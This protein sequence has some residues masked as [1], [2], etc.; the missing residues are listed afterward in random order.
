MSHM[1]HAVL[2][3]LPLVVF[4]SP[5]PHIVFL[6]TDDLGYNAPGYRNSDLHTPALD[7]LASEGLRIEEYYTYQFCSPTRGAFHTG[8]MPFRHL[9]VE[10]N[11]IP[12]SLPAG[13]DLRYDFLPLVLRRA[14]YSTHHVGKWHQGFVSPDFTPLGRGYDTT[15]G[16]LVGGE[17]HFTQDA[18]RG[19]PACNF[20]GI[21]DLSRGNNDTGLVPCIGQN[22]TGNPTNKSG[23]DAYYNGYTFA[24]EAVHVIEQFGR[25]LSELSSA[26]AGQKWN[27]SSRRLFLYFAIHNTH[28]PT[29]APVR[30]QQLYSKLANWPTRQVFNAMISV[31][32]E[33]ALNVTEALRRARLWQDTLFVWSTD[34]GSPVAVAGSNYPLKG[35]KGIPSKKCTVS[36]TCPFCT[37]TYSIFATIYLAALFAGTGSAWEGG[38]R[39]PCF[40]AGGFLPASQ[41]GRSY[42]SGIAHVADWYLTFASLAGADPFSDREGAPAPLDSLDLW[43]W[44]SGQAD[45]SPRTEVVYDHRLM[46]K[47]DF[48]Y[49][50]RGAL[51][52]GDW[53]IVVG[54]QPQAS[55][56][57]EF[58]PNQTDPKPSLRYSAC[59]Q[60]P[61][62][63]NLAVDKTEHHDVFTENPSVR[64]V[65]RPLLPC[66]T[67]CKRHCRF[68]VQ[69]VA[70]LLARWEALS[71]EYHPPVSPAN[72]DEA[73]CANVHANHGF[74]APWRTVAPA[75][76][77]PGPPKP[78]LVSRCPDIGGCSACITEHDGRCP[79][80]WCGEPCGYLSRPEGGSSSKPRGSRC[81]PLNWIAKER[82]NWNGSVTCIGNASFC[83]LACSDHS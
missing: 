56:Y 20:T 14:N 18:A 83:R 33:T 72:E 50:A 78:P 27:K 82:H 48:N 5:R 54:A 73:Y 46:D 6:L 29:E 47:K 28:N 1:M 64:V 80:P 63:Y 70:A 31:V 12:W 68:H 66:H 53:K 11:L 8:R 17:D 24:A 37:D 10:H 81:Q 13:I 61:C 41:R 39:V 52:V 34:N 7:E 40:V 15:F 32:D 35:G 77:S 44:L 30:F 67:Y 3:A 79:G 42:S 76:P 69:V 45:K 38:T 2:A 58:S 9:A 57:G 62:L 36:I 22:G 19:G 21:Y 23:G 60:T 59:G 25:E 43:P 26:P 74:V 55:W 75:P 16:F 4:G 71:D 65:V 49:S 51:R